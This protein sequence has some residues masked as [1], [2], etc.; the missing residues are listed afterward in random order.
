MHPAMLALW[1]VKAGAGRMQ[2]KSEVK[3]TLK[4]IAEHGAESPSV[5]ITNGQ[6]LFSGAKQPPPSLT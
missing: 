2:R 5:V 3:T 6:L 4:A 1:M